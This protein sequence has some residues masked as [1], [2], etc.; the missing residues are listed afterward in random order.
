M[1]TRRITAQLSRHVIASWSHLGD[2]QC[3]ARVPLGLNALHRL[4]E[5]L[6]GSGYRNEIVVIESDKK[7]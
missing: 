2:G 4:R 5:N 7:F 3:A 6:G 1:S